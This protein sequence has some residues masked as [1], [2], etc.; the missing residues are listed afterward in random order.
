[1]REHRSFFLE[2][3][4]LGGQT[5]SLFINTCLKMEVKKHRYSL[6]GE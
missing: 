3:I 6:A 5:F 2:K 1:M 4:R